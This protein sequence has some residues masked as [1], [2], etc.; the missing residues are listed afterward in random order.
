M[1]R[2]RH[3]HV[4]VLEFGTGF[5]RHLRCDD[6]TWYKTY[7]V[8]DLTGS[9]EVSC[10]DCGFRHRYRNSMPQWVRKICEELGIK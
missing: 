8:D 10:P 3:P 6:G 2:C 4:Q 5:Y 9:F 7:D 1:K